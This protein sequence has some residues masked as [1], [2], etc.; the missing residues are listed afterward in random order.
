M[1][2]LQQELR[3]AKASKGVRWWVECEAHGAVPVLITIAGP[4]S[5]CSYYVAPID[6]DWGRAFR[7][8]KADQGAG[9]DPGEKFYHVNLDEPFDTCDCRGHARHGHCKHVAV[10]REMA[11]EDL[12]PAPAYRQPVCTV[13]LGTGGHAA[14]DLDS[15]GVAC[16]ACGGSG[17]EN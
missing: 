9:S 11:A 14:G 2:I 1:K 17:W 7:F 10:A 5:T 12:E 13:C 4:R 8:E 6:S 16:R 15:D 3:S